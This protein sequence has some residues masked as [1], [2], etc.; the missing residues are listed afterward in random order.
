MS[1]ELRTPLNAILGFSQALNSGLLGQLS[2]KQSEYVGDIEA[3]GNLL[4]SLINDLLDI[5]KIEAG[6]MELYEEVFDYAHEV[7]DA[8]RLVR[9]QAD[10]KGILLRTTVDKGVRLMGDA[11]MCKQMLVNL[12]TNAIKFTPE[13]GRVSLHARCEEHGALE[14]WVTDTGQGMS[15]K[16]IETAFE[17]FGQVGQVDGPLV[18]GETGTGLGLPL[19]AA[20]IKLHGGGIDVQSAEGLGT[21]MT[22]TFPAHRV[23]VS[24]QHSLL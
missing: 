15:D 18:A 5:S 7:D 13:N 8:I 11:R 21:T 3:S 4:L 23:V 19:V 20:Q 10:S 1:H 14:V 17:K 2:S 12:L 24:G 16:D 22:L 6:R 9:Q